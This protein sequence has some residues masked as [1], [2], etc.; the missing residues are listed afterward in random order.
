[1]NLNLIRAERVKLGQYYFF[2]ETDATQ[3]DK[4]SVKLR[5]PRHVEDGWLLT[6]DEEAT[7]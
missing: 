3:R 1:M 5:L 2:G 4:T 7:S 6:L